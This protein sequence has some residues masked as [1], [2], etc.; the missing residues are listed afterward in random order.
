MWF[1]SFIPD[2]LLTWVI[3]GVVVLG[4]FLSFGGS[5]LKFIPGI[6]SY[7]SIAKQFG[8]ILLVIG[9]WFEGGIDVELSYRAKIAEMQAKI[10]IAEQ[11][12]KEANANI[13]K[14]VAEKIKNIKDNV[15]ANAKGIE[16]NRANI[17]AECKLSDTAWMLY[18][19]ASQ[20]GVARSTK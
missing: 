10:Q 11:Q 14:K 19:R 18:N 1:L 7:A 9:V 3:H 20:N 13:D 6:S 4:L 15:N 16:A 5:L 2:W 12:S 8:I 17:N